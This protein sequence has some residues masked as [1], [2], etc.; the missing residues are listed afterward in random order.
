MAGVLQVAWNSAKPPLSPSLPLP[1]SLWPLVSAQ[2]AK[3]EL[4][5]IQG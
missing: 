1:P 3:A 5:R 4:E 2:M